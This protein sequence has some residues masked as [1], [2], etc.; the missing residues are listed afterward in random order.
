M[1]L[2]VNNNCFMIPFMKDDMKKFIT[3]LKKVAK[4][5]RITQTDL[6]D[7]IGKDQTTIS[8]Y[9]NFKT[10]PLPEYIDLFCKRV[11]ESEEKIIEIGDKQL[12][13]PAHPELQKLEKRLEKLEEKQAPPPKGNITQYE[14]NKEHHDT[15]DKFKDQDTAL[16]INQKL[17]LAETIDPKILKKIEKFIDIELESAP[18][19]Q[20]PKTS[21]P[22][23]RPGKRA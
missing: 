21:D 7:C 20:E 19:K 5:K 4:A 15:V 9:F 23:E 14:R 13:P 11:D 3:G 2:N 12:S 18:N 10:R 6:A 17:V 1:N 8:N 16:R 22:G